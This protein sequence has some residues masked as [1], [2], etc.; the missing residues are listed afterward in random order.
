MER[1]LAVSLKTITAASL[2]CAMSIGLSIRPAHCADM[3]SVI[4][5][6]S[7]VSDVDARQA[8]IETRLSM[9]IVLDA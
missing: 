2:F 6:I 5:S 8:S 7:S 9:L 1:R 3:Q 4:A